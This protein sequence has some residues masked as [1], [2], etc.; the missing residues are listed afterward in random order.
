ML[1]VN[2]LFSGI[3]AQRTALERVGIPHKIVGVSE[4]DKFAIKSYTAI[5]GETKNYGDITQVKRLDYADLWTYS[6]PCTDISVAGQQKG[7][8]RGETRSGLLYEVQR[9]L[10]VAAGENTLPKYLLLENVKNLVG[11]KFRSQ[12][13]EWISWLDKLGYNSYWKVLDSK[14]FGIPQ[15]RE[16]VFA[17]SIRKDVDDGCFRFPAGFE[18]SVRLIDLLEPEVDE[19][20]YLSNETVQGVI[21]SSSPGGE[22]IVAGTVGRWSCERSNRVHNPAGIC[23]TLTPISG[24]GQEV[25]II[26]PTCCASRGR[27]KTGQAG[28]TQQLEFRGDGRTNSLTTVTKD[29]LIAEPL[30]TEKDGAVRTIK[31]SY[32]KVG[33][34]NLFR[35]DS[36]GATGVSDG[37]RIRKLTP[38]ECWRLMGFADEE[39]RKA[40]AVCSNSQ[41]Y[42]QAGNSIVVDVL[43]AIFE[44]LFDSKG[45]NET[46]HPLSI[47]KEDFYERNN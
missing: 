41:L 11:K 34:A 13:D 25:K 30:N 6:F 27:S 23:P 7:L 31:A 2:E 9:L 45:R 33:K 43:A 17:V 36:L 12:F 37:I 5:H 15:H 47:I 29:N 32:Y 28:W 22:I 42:K 4:I 3:G 39:F 21:P 40:E 16:R 38:L 44:C 1:T 35:P 20:F 24:S 10:E 14:D 19:K 8:V 18:S 46:R 26:V